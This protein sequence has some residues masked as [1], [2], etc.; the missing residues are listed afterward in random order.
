MS[1]P[2][3]SIAAAL[4]TVPLASCALFGVPG[5]GEDMGA[6]RT[7][8]LVDRVGGDDAAS[9]SIVN[10]QYRVGR[11]LVEAPLPVG[12][13][14][15][16]PPGAI[17][18]KRYPAVRRA[19]LSRDGS[20]DGGMNGAFW[21]LFNHIKD[22]DIAMTSPV[23]MD[24]EGMPLAADGRPER[25]TMS[26]LYRTADLGPAGEAGD[27]V[28]VDTDALEVL[29]VGLLGAYGMPR[30]RE[31]MA[32]LEAWLEEHPEWTIAGSPRAFWYNGPYVWDARKWSEIQVPVQRRES[33]TAA[34]N[35]G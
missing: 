16:T 11:S 32:K 22:R 31:G 15:P 12:Y 25:W 1:T 9:I 20:V 27:V 28:V 23:E 33:S 35:E 2:L 14:E 4:L 6:V 30:V 7:P 5:D 13:P 17:D 8:D 10:G 24:Y 19:E 26:F 21:P 18:L 34:A 3:R 29:S